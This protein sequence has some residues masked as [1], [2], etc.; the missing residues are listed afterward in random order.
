VRRLP[1]LITKVFLLVVLA[2]SCGRFQESGD[3]HAL[4]GFRLLSQGDYPD[5][6]RH[7]ETALQKGLSEQKYEVVYTCLGNAYNEMGEFDKSIQMHKKALDTDPSFHEAWV[8]LGIVYRLTGE[9]EEAERCYSKALELNPD[10]A[11]LHVSLGSLYIH[12]QRYEEAVQELERAV[13]LDGRLPVAWGNLALAYATVAEFDKAEAA[14]KK[15][16]L[17]GYRNGRG[18]QERI[19]ALRALAEESEDR[20]NTPDGDDPE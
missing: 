5:A 9:F 18:V 2:A 7:L 19:S 16:V 20:G 4:K 13:S 1:K 3:Q 12:Q 11:E 15:A 8:N 17:L 6:A 10:Y 14:L